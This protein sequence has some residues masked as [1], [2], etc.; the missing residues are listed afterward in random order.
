MCFPA[1]TYREGVVGCHLPMTNVGGDMLEKGL[2]V[3]YCGLEWRV[4]RFIDVY[5]LDKRKPQ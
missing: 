5:V 3:L 4:G 1:L 2:D